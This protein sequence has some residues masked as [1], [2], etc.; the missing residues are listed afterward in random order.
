MHCLD[1]FPAH[2]DLYDNIRGLCGK[3]LRL[4]YNRSAFQGNCLRENQR[5]LISLENLDDLL[6]RLLK[7]LSFLRYQ[8]GVCGGS[9][10]HACV[11]HLFDLFYIGCVD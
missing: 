8:R 10:N 1:A 4:F 7:H 9:A 5:I 3:F 2:G 6:E 11:V